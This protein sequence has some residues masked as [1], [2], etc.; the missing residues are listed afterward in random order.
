MPKQPSGRPRT[1][2]YAPGKSVNIKVHKTLDTP[3]A[4]ARTYKKQ[5]GRA[6]SGEQTIE[7]IRQELKKQSGDAVVIIR[8]NGGTRAY[9]KGWWSSAPILVDELEDMDDDDI[10]TLLYDLEDEDGPTA[11]DIYIREE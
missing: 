6:F 1:F 7:L 10:E 3:V 4:N 11:L 5:S 2:R 8:G 9:S